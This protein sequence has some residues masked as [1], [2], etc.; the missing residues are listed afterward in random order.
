MELHYSERREAKR[1]QR[2]AKYEFEIMLIP[3]VTTRG[4]VWTLLLGKRLRCHSHRVQAIWVKGN[5]YWVRF[6]DGRLKHGKKR[7]KMVMDGWIARKEKD[8]PDFV[9][10]WRKRVHEDWY[11]G[12]S[13]QKVNNWRSDNW[14]WPD[15]EIDAMKMWLGRN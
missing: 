7:V 9:Y 2:R 3:A 6:G 8:F 15:N 10:E 5:E 13:G 14:Q 1:A 12:K 4:K 11:V